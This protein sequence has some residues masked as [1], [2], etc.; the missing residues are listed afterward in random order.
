MILIFE[1][2]VQ[3][4]EEAEK[5]VMMLMEQNQVLREAQEKWRVERNELIKLL[6]PKKAKESCLDPPGPQRV[7]QQCFSS[8]CS[9]APT[10]APATAPTPAPAT[11]PTPTAA[12]TPT[13]AARRTSIHSS[14]T[15]VSQLMPAPLRRPGRPVSVLFLQN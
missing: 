3:R 10:T 5:S 12:P 4:L 14:T 9:T 2:V 6:P 15:Q 13:P 1:D 8:A 11:A 7:L